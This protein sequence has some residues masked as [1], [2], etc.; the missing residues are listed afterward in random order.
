MILIT[1]NIQ[2]CLGVDGVVDPARIVDHARSMGDFDVLCLQEVARNYPGLAGSKGEDQFRLL[3]GL[4]P[5][6]TAIEGV[7]VDEHYAAGGRREFGN[8]ILSRLPVIQVLRHLLPWPAD[9]QVPTMPRIAIEAVLRTPEGPL[10]VTT[11]HLEYHSALQRD[12]QIERIREV[13]LE[14]TRHAADV[15][16]DDK[17]GGPFETKAR[18]ASGILTG[19]FNYE[20]AEPIHARLQA[21]LPGGVPCYVDAWPV[22]NPGKAHAPTVGVFD[23]VQWKGREFCCDFICVTEDLLPRVRRVAVDLQTAASDHQPVLLELG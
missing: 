20:V 11:T 8:M 4:L 6:F 14:A 18:G 5:G 1:W 19:D 3:A 17:R 9:P 2:W 23:K 7:A 15:W 12:A 21:P 10:R 13:Q 22:A 16:H